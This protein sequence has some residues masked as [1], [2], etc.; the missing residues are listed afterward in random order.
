MWST[1]C[2]VSFLC[3]VAVAKVTIVDPPELYK[4]FAAPQLRSL[5]TNDQ[6]DIE[7]QL[8]VPP[9]FNF[10]EGKLKPNEDFVDKI[11]LLDLRGLSFNNCT[12]DCRGVSSI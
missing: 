6:F 11:V 12:N 5:S 8:L 10:C 7:G 2:I 9:D 1:F 3:S 4:T